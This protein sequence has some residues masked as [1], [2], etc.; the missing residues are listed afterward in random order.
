MQSQAVVV[1]LE[2]CLQEEKYGFDRDRD[3]RTGF[4]GVLVEVNLSK[5]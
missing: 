3:Y 1:Y 5:S 4:M 2:W